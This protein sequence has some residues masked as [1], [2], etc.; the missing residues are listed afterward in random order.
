MNKCQR[1]FGSCDIPNNPNNPPWLRHCLRI[2][3]L[4]RNDATGHQFSMSYK[5]HPA[6]K[7]PTTFLGTTHPPQITRPTLSHYDA[8]NPIVFA[9]VLLL[10]GFSHEYILRSKRTPRKHTIRLLHSHWQGLC[11]KEAR[12]P[13]A[14]DDVLSHIFNRGGRCRSVCVWG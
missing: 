4:P 10:D 13:R 9:V 6:H 5:R 8:N 2:I 7:N 1:Y 14:H 3:Y 11:G 12:T